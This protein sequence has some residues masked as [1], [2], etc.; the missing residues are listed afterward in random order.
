MRKFALLVLVVSFG[1]SSGASA[2]PITGGLVAGY[3]FNGNANDVSGN[4]NNGVVHGATPTTDRFGNANSAYLF[5]GVDDYLAYSNHISGHSEFTTAFWLNPVGNSGA[6][7][8]DTG[9]DNIFLYSNGDLSFRIQEDRVGGTASNPSTVFWY[10]AST[11]IPDGTWT[12][13]AFTA[14]G[15]NSAE[16]FING[17]Q[18]A[19]PTVVVDGGQTGN[20]F[21]STIG[22]NYLDGGQSGS[23]GTEHNFSGTLDDVYRYNRALS[24]SE[25]LTLATIPEPNTAL[26]LGV[27]LAG[28]G[29]R[30]R[31]V[32]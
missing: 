21:A 1:W 5:D 18:V 4:G 3:D 7:L 14:Y 19:T 10:T 29:M 30:R 16:I 6:Y 23:A 15:D 25:V 31:R 9:V 8:T 13:V 26:L 12:H 22:A 28:L 11:E 24:A 17:I 2:V 20:T 27:G 32:L